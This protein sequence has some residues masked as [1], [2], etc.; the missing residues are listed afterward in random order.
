VSSHHEAQYYKTA[1][2]VH[3]MVVY[4]LLT[5]LLALELLCRRY[6]DMTGMLLLHNN[7]MQR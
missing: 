6:L 3:S 5:A 7:I 4:K 1:L 2:I